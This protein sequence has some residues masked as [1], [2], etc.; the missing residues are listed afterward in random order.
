MINITAIVMASGMSR[1]MMLDKL[2]LKIND[3]YIYEYILE[4]IKRYDFF[5]TLVVAKDRDILERAAKLGFLGVKNTKYYLGQSES[6]KA[7][8]RIAKVT[9]GFMFFV[10]DQPFIELNTIE[11]LCNEFKRDTSKI[12]QPFY[13]GTKGNPVIFPY[14][15]KDQLLKLKDDQG[16]K[17][18]VN[19]NQ[20]IIKKVDI[21]TRFENFDIDTMDDYEKAKKLYINN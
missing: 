10:A 6:I 16:G 13:N 17:I 1:R 19:N 11:R 4:T 15:L 8:L 7:A 12:V 18:V 20:D 9:D 5:E 14:Y 2:H 21:H 3:K